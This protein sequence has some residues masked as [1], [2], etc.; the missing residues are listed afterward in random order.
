[1]TIELSSDET[2]LFENYRAANAGARGFILRAAG[3]DLSYEGQLREY[4]QLQP[5]ESE[6]LSAY[7][8][9]DDAKRES[10][11]A[12]SLFMEPSP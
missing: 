10:I 3:V 1:M 9:A 7:R 2:R 4:P 11:R 6:L 8:R 5:D 12:H